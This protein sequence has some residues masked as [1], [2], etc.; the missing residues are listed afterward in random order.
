MSSFASSYPWQRVLAA[1]PVESSASR[2]TVS[3][4]SYAKVLAFESRAQNG[5]S[6]RKGTRAVGIKFHHRGESPSL[7]P[8]RRYR[9]GGRFCCELFH[10]EFTGLARHSEPVVDGRGR[11]A[12]LDPPQVV[13]VPG[14]A[15]L[16]EAALAV[17]QLGARY[18]GD[19]PRTHRCGRVRDRGGGWVPVPSRAPTGRWPTYW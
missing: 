3:S 10:L 14:E 1:P 13:Q 11:V 16:Q 6:N 15:P 4:R 18:R 17:T 5:S 2:Q 19:R 8:N 9:S 12:F 7:S